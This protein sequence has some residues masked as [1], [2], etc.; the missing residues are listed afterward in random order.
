M[1][2]CFNQH[3]FI[4]EADSIGIRSPSPRFLTFLPRDRCSSVWDDAE[5]R[6]TFALLFYRTALFHC[7]SAHVR[8]LNVLLRGMARAL[9]ID[10][11]TS[12]PRPR[13]R[14]ARSLCCSNLNSTH[15]CAACPSLC[16]AHPLALAASS[17]QTFLP[18]LVDSMACLSPEYQQSSPRDMPLDFKL[19]LVRPS[20]C[21]HVMHTACIVTRR[22]GSSCLEGV[23]PLRLLRALASTL[24]PAFVVSDDSHVG[25]LF[26]VTPPHQPLCSFQNLLA[27][28]WFAGASSDAVVEVEA[29]CST[30]R[31]LPPR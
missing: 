12:T 16:L 18:L 10:I 21:H 28:S 9:Q 7:R 4:A 6:L 26:P 30:P 22:P 3:T 2:T 20:I 19:E 8:I 1:T 13:T 11:G 17:S 27:T 31:L 24:P 29:R 14:I 15:S 5:F 25:V 23:A